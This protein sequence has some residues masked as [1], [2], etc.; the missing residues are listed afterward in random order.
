MRGAAAVSARPM[1]L[2][3]KAAAV[4]IALTLTHNGDWHPR[5]ARERAIRNWKARK[6]N[7]TG[8][9]HPSERIGWEGWKAITRARYLR[10]LE[11]NAA[12]LERSR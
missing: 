7:L 2:E 12:M 5:I 4:R 10:W 1:G 9:P 11:R 8:R 6:G 3:S